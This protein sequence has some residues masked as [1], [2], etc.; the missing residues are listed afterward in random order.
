MEID[1]YFRDRKNPN[2]KGHRTVDALS[3]EMLRK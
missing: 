2:V 3:G 1:R